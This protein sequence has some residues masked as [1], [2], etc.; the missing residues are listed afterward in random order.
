MRFSPI[1]GGFRVRP[2]EHDMPSFL[3]NSNQLF[4]LV[5][6]GYLQYPNLEE[7]EIEDRNKSDELTRWLAIAQ[8]L[9]STLNC[10][11]RFAQG[12]FVT[13]IELTT[14][15]FIITFLITSYFWY[16]KPMGI[17]TPFILELQTSMAIRH[18]HQVTGLKWY[19]TPFDYLS[20]KRI[21]TLE[22]GNI[23][24]KFYA[25]CIYRCLPGLNDDHTSV[26]RLSIG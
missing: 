23:I 26:F 10:I 5:K 9:W 6:D 1:W 21:S 15:T 7:E 4:T 22:L 8:T 11:F 24:I 20:R 25:L 18:D 16:H 12:L 13:T 14:L 17:T 3:L 2:L 19:Q